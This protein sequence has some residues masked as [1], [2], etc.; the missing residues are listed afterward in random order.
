METILIIEDVCPT[1]GQLL[2]FQRNNIR[3][4]R[5]IT[6][7]RHH[8]FHLDTSSQR[9]SQSSSH[10]FH[11]CR[12]GID[13]LYLFLSGI[14]G[15]NISLSHSLGISIRSTFN[16]TYHLLSCGSSSVWKENKI[17][18]WTNPLDERTP[19]HGIVIRHSLRCINLIQ[20]YFSCLLPP[21]PCKKRFVLRHDV[22]RQFHVYIA[23]STIIWP[24]MNIVISDIH[25]PS[26]THST[27]YH[28]NFAMVAV[29]SMIKPREFHR[30]KL[31]HLYA[32][33]PELSQVSLPQRT[34]ITTIP[35]PIKHSTHL[36]TLERLLS[37]QVKECHAYTIVTEIEIFQVDE[38]FSL[39]YG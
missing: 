5:N 14:N 20:Q 34:V 19:F 7:G 9:S 32:L 35:K 16:N 2:H 25:T 4:Y 11:V 30:V 39:A 33:L 23:K 13:N 12:V 26:I 27:I 36:H 29:K 37:K 28:H 24:S 15:S 17:C 1:F 31:R 18:C 21:H 10:A 38:V 8:H 3:C 22:T 6:F